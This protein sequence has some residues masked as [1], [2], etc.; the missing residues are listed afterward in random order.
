MRPIVFSAAEVRALAEGR[1]TQTRRPVIPQ[2]FADGHYA[3]EVEFDGWAPVS[4]GQ[5]PIARFTAQAVSRA[6][7]LREGSPCRYGGPGDRLW[8]KEAWRPIAHQS[9]CVD[10]KDVLFAAS[11]GETAQA[12]GEWYSPIH[13]P[14]WAA[15]FVLEIAEV[16]VERVQDISEADAIAEGVE[17]RAAF[18]EGWDFHHGP[19]AW[20]RNDWIWVLSHPLPTLD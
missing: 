4:T 15:R 8:V 10:T 7:Y 20:A 9:Q 6:G 16:R 1:K 17:A 2:P 12:V 14:R 3:G 19:G 13:M 18:A 5:R 11:V